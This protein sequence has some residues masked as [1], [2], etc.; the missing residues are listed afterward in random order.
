MRMV[1]FQSTMMFIFYDTET[2]GLTAGFDQILQFA[3]IVTDDNLEPIEEVNLRCRLQPHI[4]PSPGAFAVTGVYPS[5]VAKANLSHYE[6]MCQIRALFEK[7]TP[8]ISA[9][10]NSIRFD[11]PMLRQAFYQT[12]N[13]VYLTNTGGNSRLDI[14]KLVHA[15]S[16]YAPDILRIPI[17]DKGKP[18]FKLELLALE[19]GLLH[20]D[21]HEAMSDTLAT[22]G[23]AKLV[24]DKAPDIWKALLAT[25]SKS[26]A[27][28]ILDRTKLFCQTEKMFK[29][30]SVLA[31]KIMSNIDNSSEFAVFDMSYEPSDFLDATEEEIGDLLKKNPR[32]I[33]VVK[34][35]QNP[36][37]ISF[38]HRNSKVAGVDQSAEELERKF[39]S[40]QNHPT[41]A[42][43]VGRVL[44]DRY[45]DKEPS[46]F[47]EQR[48]YDGF[49]TTPDSILLD[50]F[51][52]RPWRERSA[53]LKQ[54][55]DERLR[56]LGERLIYLEYPNALEESKRL[57][58]DAWIGK[59]FHAEG[60]V[61][62]LTVEAAKEELMNFREEDNG[63]KEP[64]FLD[65]EHFLN[66]L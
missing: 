60:D 7:Y 15:V 40:I 55:G 26:N 58:Y 10:Y 49:L 30:S 3:A 66:E 1:R 11:D 5:E 37:L 51:H 57:E 41:F 28:T 59:R 63:D 53:I 33:R 39:L 32:P 42:A 25:S 44:A 45:P 56:E 52:D 35:N 47:V 19:N 14:M 34:A 54:L 4:V 17:N 50:D 27:V 16:E 20:E 46:E 23:L 9:G 65:I 21:A 12:L 64:I 48:M 13:P 43:N 2:T 31:T 61:P 18:S 36:I 29:Q 22:L 8:T 24:K 62:W 38:K 6:M